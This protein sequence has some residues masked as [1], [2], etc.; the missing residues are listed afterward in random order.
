MRVLKVSKA[1]GPNGIPNRAL[2]RLSKRAVSILSRDLYAVLR[3][4]HFPQAWKHARV[5][6]I[7]KPGKDA[8]LSS[9]YRPI[10]LLVSI[11]KLFEK[12]LLARMLYVVNE[13]LLLGDEQ[14]GFRP[15]R[16]TSLQLARLV[17]K[18]ARN[19]GE[20]GSPAHFSST[21]PKPSIPSVSMTSSTN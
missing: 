6:Y 3:T 8:S 11:G 18:I 17:E 10:S 14:F 1:P 5:I 12:I 9:S 21:W 4:H 7:F 19:F 2:K 20:K 13:R 16:S 15:V